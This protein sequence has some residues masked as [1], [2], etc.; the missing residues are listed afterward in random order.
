MAYIENKY[1]ATSDPSLFQ[2]YLGEEFTRDQLEGFLQNLQ[3]KPDL[4]DTEK[5]Y[6]IDL[7][8]LVGSGY[9]EA[10]KSEYPPATDYL[11]GIVKGDT[12]QVQAYIDACLAV[13]AKY[14]KPE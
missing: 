12:A 9:K 4:T 2:N 5:K 6:L 3:D 14:P 10:R 11:D 13:K 1:I 8:G 7:D